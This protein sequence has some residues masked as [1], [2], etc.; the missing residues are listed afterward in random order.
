LSKRIKARPAQIAAD[1]PGEWSGLQVTGRRG[2][3]TGGE[4]WKKI[5]GMVQPERR[6]R[7]WIVPSFLARAAEAKDD[8]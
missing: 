4:G 7:I 8:R 2:P 1:F 3:W 6:T 5:A